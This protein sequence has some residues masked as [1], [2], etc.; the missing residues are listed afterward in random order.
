M[1]T[2]PYD[3]RVLQ[4][5]SSSKGDQIDNPNNPINSSHSTN[6]ITIGSSVIPIRNVEE[7]SESGAFAT[8]LMNSASNGPSSISLMNRH[9]SS[10]LDSTNTATK[11]GS[12]VVPVMERRESLGFS[13]DLNNGVAIGASVI[14]LVNKLQDI[15]APFKSLSPKIKLPQVVVIG[16]QSSG[17]S[18]VLEALVGRDFLPR[19]CDICTRRPLVLQ[20]ENRQCESD[21]DGR[22]WG[23]FLHLPGKRLYDFS[24]IRRE[25]QAETEREAGVNKDISDKQIRLRIFSPNVLNI[26]LVD[27]PGITKVPVGDQPSDIE[28]RIRTMIVS[29]INHKACIILAVTPANADLATSDALQMARIADPSG[30]LLLGKTHAQQ[31]TINPP[32][33][34]QGFRQ[35]QLPSIEFNNQKVSIFSDLASSDPSSILMQSRVGKKML[36]LYNLLLHVKDRCLIAPPPWSP[37]SSLK[38]AIIVDNCHVVSWK[39]RK[40]NIKNREVSYS[41]AKEDI[42]PLS[43]L[44]DGKSQEMST[45]EL[46]GGARIHYLFQSVFVKR[47][48][49]VD[50]CDG[51]TDE[52]IWTAIQNSVGPKNV[53]FVPEV[54]LEVLVRRQ[55]VRLLDPSLKCLHLVYD[56][57]IKVRKKRWRLT[58]FLLAQMDYINTSHPN[59]IDGSEAV[60]IAIQQLRPSKDAEKL[61]ASGRSIKSL[62]VLAKSVSNGSLPDQAWPSSGRSWAISSIFGAGEARRSSEFSERET[63]GKPVNVHEHSSRIQLKENNPRFLWC[64]CVALSELLAFACRENLFDEMLHEQEDVITGRKRA[65][66]IY[67]ALHNSFQ[68]GCYRHWEQLRL[69]FLLPHIQALR[70][71]PLWGCIGLLTSIPLATLI[72]QGD[73]YSSYPLYRP[74]WSFHSRKA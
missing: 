12:S 7:K 29:Y 32:P 58:V 25:I 66:E 71:T 34:T 42:E 68:T 48:E 14:P 11:I 46:T 35:I 16:S 20:L 44:V 26:T 59:F 65:R 27:L 47:L 21:R 8:D 64:L 39:N 73:I 53:L 41:V 74:S 63:N 56:E 55:I 1:N 31:K 9:R 19:G 54:P 30:M 49:E 6:T 69:T 24:A 5:L 37:P 43:S 60:E 40:Y 4:R 18:S 2:K 3:S 70:M 72:S 45:L 52:D 50:P 22:E 10:V 57:L 23:E 67:E 61:T 38:P 15:F 62:A 36:G 17:K 33:T 28:K 13:K 51:L